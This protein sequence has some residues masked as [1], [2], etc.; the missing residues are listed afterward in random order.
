[1]K[2]LA[3]DL[4]KTQ[5]R[6][7]AKSLHPDKNDSIIAAVNFGRVQQARDELLELNDIASLRTSWKKSI[8][9]ETTTQED[10]FP[11]GLQLLQQFLTTA[12]RSRSSTVQ[13]S[14]SSM[15]SK[16]PL[17]PAERDTAEMTAIVLR[18]KRIGANQF[19]FAGGGGKR[20]MGINATP[21]TIRSTV[22][23]FRSC[24]LVA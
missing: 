7:K 14:T 3:R 23:N 2:K 5:F 4:I 10:M 11:E 20:K 16:L 24:V 18:N 1:M 21:S 17:R 12:V 6:A 8:G 22:R 9:G 13:A 19:V 15:P